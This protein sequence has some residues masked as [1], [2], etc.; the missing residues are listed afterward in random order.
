MLRYLWR[1]PVI[2]LHHWPVLSSWTTNHS[3]NW[4]VVS[5]TVAKYW[6]TWTHFNE[7]YRINLLHTLQAGEMVL[8]TMGKL[9]PYMGRRH[10]AGAKNWSCRHSISYCNSI[11]IVVIGCKQED[12]FVLKEFSVLRDGRFGNLRG[13]K[14]RYRQSNGQNKE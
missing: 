1:K 13:V 7:R 8:A 11:I 9:V 5:Q 6:V 12:V 10:L 14:V 2:Q 4:A 3:Q